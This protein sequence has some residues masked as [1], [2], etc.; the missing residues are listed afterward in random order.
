METV[1]E[2]EACYE[3]WDGGAVVSTVASKQEGS[4]FEHNHMEFACLPCACVG[5]QVCMVVCLYVSLYHIP[6]SDP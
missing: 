3:F 1:P 2:G 4:G 6:L 5:F